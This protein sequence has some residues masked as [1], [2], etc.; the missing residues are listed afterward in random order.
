MERSGGVSRW[1]GF[2]FAGALD[3]TPLVGGCFRHCDEVCRTLGI[4]TTPVFTALGH[5]NARPARLRQRSD[6]GV[7]DGRR[8]RRCGP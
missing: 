6:G 1:P 8:K 5:L 2:G 4:P 7:A 3:L